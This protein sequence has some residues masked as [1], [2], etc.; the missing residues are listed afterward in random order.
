MKVQVIQDDRGRATGIF[1]PISQWKEMKKRY[2]GLAE[3]E[4]SDVSK[5]QLILELKEAIQELKLIEQGR[6]KSRPASELLNEL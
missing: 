5:N 2:Q 3:M 1:I 4:E 6:I